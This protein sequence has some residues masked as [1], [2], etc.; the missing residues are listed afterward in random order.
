LLSAATAALCTRGHRL[1]PSV[2]VG[3]GGSVTAPPS[4]SR[5]RRPSRFAPPRDRRAQACSLTSVEPPYTDPDV[6]W[7]GRGGAARLPPIPIQIRAQPSH[8]TPT[9][10]RA[11]LRYW[12]MIVKVRGS[13]RPPRQCGLTTVPCRCV[14]PDRLR[15]SFG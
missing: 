6:R 13:F 1:S 4:P 9:A 12:L 5:F 2:A 11:R 14:C 3:T 7:C 8:G 15:C 10:P